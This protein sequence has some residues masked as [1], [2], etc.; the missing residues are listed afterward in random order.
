[1]GWG[2]GGS[3]RGG[4]TGTLAEKLRGLEAGRGTEPVA[5]AELSDL[6]PQGNGKAGTSVGRGSLVISKGKIA[7]NLFIDQ[8]GYLQVGLR[9]QTGK[10]VS[11]VR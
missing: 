6:C 1:M 8:I 7:T 9:V 10:T 4:R 3:G 2:V 5:Q 11:F